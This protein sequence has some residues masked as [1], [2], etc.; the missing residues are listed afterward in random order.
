MRV[1][2]RSS[3]SGQAT[4]LTIVFMTVLLG[5]CCAVLDVGHWYHEKRKLQA[6]VDAAALAGAQAL[7]E[8][9]GQAK[10]NALAYA[11]KNGGGVTG[12][13]VTFSTTYLA[14]D[15]IR[16]TGQKNAPGLFSSIFGFGTV[17]VHAS[18][19]ARTGATGSPL[20][21]TIPSRLMEYG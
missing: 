9:T 15:T 21:T 18:A 17:T 11:S 10:A 3:N 16:V 19:K 8:N 14:N 4:V 20:L 2:R 5:M 13:D 1:P 6:T 12:G 7:P